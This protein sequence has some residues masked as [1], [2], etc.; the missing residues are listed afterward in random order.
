MSENGKYAQGPLSEKGVWKDLID[1]DGELPE[2][3][4]RSEEFLK[5][6]KLA[7]TVKKVKPDNYP[8]LYEASLRA[9]EDAGLPQVHVY[10]Y[11]N[12][13]GGVG[14]SIFSQGTVAISRA[15]AEE[16]SVE[17]LEAI[18][19]HE[20]RHHGQDE[21]IE[22]RPIVENQIE[23]AE[24]RAGIRG[25]LGALSTIVA[26]VLFSQGASAGESPEE[27]VPP[28]SNFMD[29]L[30]QVGEM[31]AQHVPEIA[32]GVGVTLFG[33]M[34]ASTMLAGAHKRT[35]VDMKHDIE[36]DADEYAITMS[37]VPEAYIDVLKEV[38]SYMEDPDLD[39]DNHPAINKRI[40]HAEEVLRRRQDSGD[41]SSRSAAV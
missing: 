27:V 28:A 9:S 16:H 13:R 26:G 40:S 37:S 6:V 10:V 20:M 29:M 25:V 35:L 21:Y 38:A 24:S 7:H 5:R 32:I 22:N 23:S 39:T 30:Q 14:A 11:D 18:L 1:E 34:A 33:A 19:L 41:L 8:E 31:A 17:Q 2:L 12:D 15:T 36:Y 3:G 4:F